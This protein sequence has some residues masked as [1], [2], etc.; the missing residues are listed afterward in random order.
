[1]DRIV[2]QMFFIGRQVFMAVSLACGPGGW[3]GRL[4]L[5][6]LMGVGRPGRGRSAGT[7]FIDD[8]P[9]RREDQRPLCGSGSVPRA[10][11]PFFSGTRPTDRTISALLL[12]D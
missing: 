11:V 2:R 9:P 7:R 8:P 10:S 12:P 5:V 3:A 6:T 4:A 1:M